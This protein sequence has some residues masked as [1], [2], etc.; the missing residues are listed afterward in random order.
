MLLDMLDDEEK[1]LL[2]LPV[3]V[4]KVFVIGPDKK[5]KLTLTYPPAYVPRGVQR[6]AS[7][8]GSVFMPLRAS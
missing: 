4:R 7:W 2:G 8:R 5:I 3:T 6:D 1:D